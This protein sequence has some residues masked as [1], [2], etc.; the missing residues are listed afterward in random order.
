MTDLQHIYLITYKGIYFTNNAGKRWDSFPT[1][2]NYDYDALFFYDQGT[3]YWTEYK[4]IV[5]L[6]SPPRLTDNLFLKCTSDFGKT[7]I[8][9]DSGFDG[10][11]GRSY[12]EKFRNGLSLYYSDSIYLKAISNC[13]VSDKISLS[14]GY[15]GRTSLYEN[16]ELGEN[17]FLYRIDF[18]N[19]F[20]R[21]KFRYK[22]S[23]SGKLVTY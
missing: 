21:S 7:Q 13:K 11:H 9:I 14:V 22:M 5:Y 19:K 6:D 8:T 2:D 16:I 18:D 17:G 12:F 20:Y 1:I 23:E 15:H 4:G 3:F 10:N